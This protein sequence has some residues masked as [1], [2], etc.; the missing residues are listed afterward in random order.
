VANTAAAPHRVELIWHGAGQLYGIN[1]PLQGVLSAYPVPMQQPK[2][3]ILGDSQQGTWIDYGGAHMG[4]E[5]AQ[6]LGMSDKYVG[7]HVGG[8]GWDVDNTSTTP[9]GL[10]WSDSRRIADVIAQNLMYWSSLA[11]KTT[12]VPTAALPPR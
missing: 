8:T 2:L 12:P 11:V 3:V 10:K 9:N 4:L 5:I 6:R 7:S 1:T